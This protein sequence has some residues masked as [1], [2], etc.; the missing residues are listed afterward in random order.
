M[1]FTFLLFLSFLGAIYANIETKNPINVEVELDGSVVL[2]CPISKEFGMWN[3]TN[4][5]QK[6]RTLFDQNRV[7]S[8]YKDRIELQHDYTLVI[9]YVQ[10]KDAGTYTCIFNN[11]TVTS[12]REFILKVRGSRADYIRMVKKRQEKCNEECK[13]SCYETC[14]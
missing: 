1:N 4:T 7:A 8:S 9:N 14:K 12:K 10:K 5:K 3:Y 11:K 2:P 6:T 13:S